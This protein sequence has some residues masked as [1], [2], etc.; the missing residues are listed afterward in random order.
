[1]NLRDLYKY[2]HKIKD[3]HPSLKDDVDEILS[4]ATDEISS[5]ES[6]HNECELAWDELE[7]LEK[8]ANST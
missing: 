7:D 2:G 8:M 3:Q 4:L 1:M 6:E 5:G